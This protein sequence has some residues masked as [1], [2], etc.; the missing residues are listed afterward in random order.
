MTQFA[1]LAKEFAGQLSGLAEALQQVAARGGAACK[2]GPSSDEAQ[3]E[4]LLLDAGAAHWTDMGN[5]TLW[6][7]G[8]V[9]FPEMGPTVGELQSIMGN[10]V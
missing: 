3:V 5:R 9:P 1:A 8:G 6:A 2:S 10:H 4:K 7:L